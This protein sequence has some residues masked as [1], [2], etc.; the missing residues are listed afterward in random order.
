M[1]VSVDY[2][3]YDFVVDY[4]EIVTGKEWEYIEGT[5]ELCNLMVDKTKHLYKFNK[6]LYST[7]GRVHRFYNNHYNENVELIQ[8]VFFPAWCLLQDKRL[9]TL[10][11]TKSRTSAKENSGLLGK[12]LQSDK[13]RANFCD[14]KVEVR[15]DS[16][17][18]TVRVIEFNGG[19]E[20]NGMF[21]YTFSGCC[22]GGMHVHI[23]IF[24]NFMGVEEKEKKYA[25]GMIR[26]LWNRVMWRDNNVVMFFNRTPMDWLAS[27][28]FEEREDRIVKDN[29]DAT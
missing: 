19:I 13:M 18:P 29:K 11:A 2:R 26:S 5:H 7:D 20:N 27:E 23:C 17:F 4:W 22:T 15:S 28:L 10:V 12:L 14:I 24:S 9:K 1:T 6:S 21:F 3:F 16:S 8:C 25:Q